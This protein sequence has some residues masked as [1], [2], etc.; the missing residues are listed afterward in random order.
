MSRLLHID[1]L[2]VLLYVD[3]DGGVAHIGGVRL[4]G[5]LVDGLYGRAAFQG[6]FTPCFRTLESGGFIGSD[7]ELL[8]ATLLP[9]LEGGRLYVDFQFFFV[10]RTS[11]YQK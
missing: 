6:Y 9:E 5:Y 4:Y 1:F 3:G 7:A 2:H 8:A 11:H 10:V